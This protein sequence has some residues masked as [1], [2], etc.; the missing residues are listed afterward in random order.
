MK[1][2]TPISKATVIATQ[3]APMARAWSGVGR[4]RRMVG[5]DDDGDEEADQE[6]AHLMGGVFTQAR[7][8][9][10]FAQGAADHGDEHEAEP[11][12]GGGGEQP[13]HIGSIRVT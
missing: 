8:E 5:D 3:P 13:F 12:Q 2:N 7:G 1:W 9:Q 6:R 10:G 4:R 11:G